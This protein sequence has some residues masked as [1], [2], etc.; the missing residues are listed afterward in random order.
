MKPSRWIPSLLCILST[1]SCTP[2]VRQ[3]SPSFV[4]KLRKNSTPREPSEFP[5]GQLQ[6]QYPIRL[7]P[8]TVL[9]FPMQH[10]HRI[11]GIQAKLN[12]HN[13]PWI[14]D[15]GAGFPVLI[16]AKSA[17]SVHIPVIRDVRVKG[18]GVG[19]NTDMLLGRFHSM[20]FANQEVL[21]PGIAGILLRTYHFNFAGVPVRRVPLNLLGLPFL[22]LFSFVTLDGPQREVQLGYKRDFHPA[23][24]AQSFPF[25]KDGS[26]LWITVKI[27]GRPIEAFLDTGYGSDLRLPACELNKLPTSARQ[28]T[29]TQKRP[30]M[31]VGGVEM[32]ETGFIKE[33][34]IGSI[35]LA[36]VEIETSENCTEAMVGWGAF[37]NRRITIDFQQNRVWV[38]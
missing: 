31:G 35:R 19:G 28:N 17:A 21:G 27:A 3:A 36:H 18:T 8:G 23:T 2:Y 20:T 32:E 15:T 5:H 37:R 26:R 22:E 6:I 7:R 14:L 29:A 30:A 11:P 34:H 13:F 33:A 1:T 9:H 25:R 38:E 16:D 12:H 24:T 4:Q 10:S